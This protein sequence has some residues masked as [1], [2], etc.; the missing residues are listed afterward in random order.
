MVSGSLVGKDKGRWSHLHSRGEA[1]IPAQPHGTCGAHTC[2][3]TLTHNKMKMNKH[4]LKDSRHWGGIY[5]SSYRAVY[6]HNIDIHSLDKYSLYIKYSSSVDFELTQQTFCTACI[7]V[8]IIVTLLRA[9][10]I[11][12]S[13]TAGPAQ[14]H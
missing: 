5:F 3:R 7:L 9:S 13:Q 10:L 14:R 12:I 6:T 2:G 1:I 11:L 8:G 4:V